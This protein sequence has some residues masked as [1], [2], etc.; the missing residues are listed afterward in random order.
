[1]AFA[2]VAELNFY[3][4]TTVPSDRANLALELASAACENAAQR[5]DGAIE[6][7]TDVEVAVDGSGIAV[8]HLPLWPVI[9]VAT[10]EVDGDEV[11]DFTWTRRGTLVRTAGRWPHG[12]RNIVVT[13]SYGL[14]PVP[15]AIKAVTLQAA[16]RA[17][18]N[19]A[20]LNSFADGQVSVGFGGGGTGTQVL[21]LLS[22]ETTMV[23]RAIR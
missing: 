16:S 22:N 10:V 20:R 9:D 14:D 17:I 23:V 2:T 1:M 11:E 21:D 18:L 19:P 13:Y 4:D 8:V 12:Q 15:D 6:V 5:V 7:Q 3:T